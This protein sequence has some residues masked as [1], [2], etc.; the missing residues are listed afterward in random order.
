MALWFAISALSGLAFLGAFLFWPYQYV[1]PGDPG[2]LMYSLYTP[3]VGA[4]FGLSVLAV[5][6]GVIAYIKK[7]FPDEVS[8][9]QRHDGA[10]DDVA[11]LTVTAQLVKAGQ[12]T[13]IARR[14]LI[15]RTRGRRRGRPR[16]RAGHRGGRAAG[17]QPVEGRRQGRAV[18]HR[19]E[20]DRTARRS[21]CAATRATRTR[22]RSCGPRT[23]RPAPWRRCS[24]SGSPSGT[25]RRP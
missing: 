17:A 22:C 6:I 3:V 9:Q 4:M 19:L 10:S 15:V 8:V 1:A 16:P 5:G 7:F 13:D 20:A 12:E 14:K 23:R 18:G 2:Y 25:T 24:R 11:R 21:T